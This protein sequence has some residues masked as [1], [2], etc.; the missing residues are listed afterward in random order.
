MASFSIVYDGKHGKSVVSPDP[1]MDAYKYTAF[2]T[3]DGR[4][5]QLI[6]HSDGAVTA[7]VDGLMPLTYEKAN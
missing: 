6:F 4:G 3:Q 1:K 7:A 5:Y 2:V